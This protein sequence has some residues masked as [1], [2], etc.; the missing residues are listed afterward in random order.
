MSRS[1]WWAVLCLLASTGVVPAHA[2]QKAFDVSENDF[3][4]KVHRVILAPC[5]FPSYFN[6]SDTL[7]GLADSV[8]WRVDSLTA[9]TL[10]RYGFEVISARESKRVY[11]AVVDSLGGLY[12]PVSGQ[13]DTAKFALAEEQTRARLRD[14]HHPDAWAFPVVFPVNA[15]FDHA[16][17]NWHGVTEKISQQSFGR[18]LFKALTLRSADTEFMGT[19]GA[20]SLGLSMENDDGKPLYSW[21]GGIHTTVR[22]NEGEFTPLPQKD[23]FADGTRVDNSVAIALKAFTKAADKR[24]A[25]AQRTR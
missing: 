5:K 23:Y 11:D 19:V 21:A 4:T 16:V 1:T 10:A 17:A 18:G 24:Q 20:L 14:L 7:M 8:K 3:F 13:S 6:T 12:D 25:K 15:R 2:G 9:Q 22:F